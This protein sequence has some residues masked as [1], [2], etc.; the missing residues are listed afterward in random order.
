MIDGCFHHYEKWILEYSNFDKNRYRKWLYC[1]VIQ[2]I[3]IV[4]NN[5]LY[6]I[7]TSTLNSFKIPLKIDVNEIANLSPT[8]FSIHANVQ[9]G[10]NYF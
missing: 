10:G 6:K 5:Y 4:N 3:W 7:V 1:M 8:F 2:K 9:I